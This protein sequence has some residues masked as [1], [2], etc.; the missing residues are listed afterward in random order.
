MRIS[1]QF[2]YIRGSR[3]YYYLREKLG[4]MSLPRDPADLDAGHACVIQKSIIG[5]LIALAKS[6]V[7]KAFFAKGNFIRLVQV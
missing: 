5:R 4:S 1:S 3:F 2:V 6:A 7:G